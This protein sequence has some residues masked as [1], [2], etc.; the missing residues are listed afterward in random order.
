MTKFYFVSLVLRWYE[1]WS[2]IS[3]A[4]LCAR[5]TEWLCLRNANSELSA[6]A[7][8]FSELLTIVWKVVLLLKYPHCKGNDDQLWKNFQS[9]SLLVCQSDQC[10]V[11]PEVDMHT[12]GLVDIVLEGRHLSHMQPILVQSLPLYWVPS[13]IS[14]EESHQS[15]EPGIVPIHL[16]VCPQPQKKQAKGKIL[17]YLYKIAGRNDR[18][19]C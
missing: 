8:I 19:V 2:T 6:L 18:Y 12:N 15:T 11:K 9:M 17:W 14:T 1:A 10:R 4:V 16:Q 7:I 3:K 5:L 13:P